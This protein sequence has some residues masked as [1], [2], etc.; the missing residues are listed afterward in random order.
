MR[1][2]AFVFATLAFMAFAQDAGQGIQLYQSGDY[3]QAEKVLA[4]AVT[5]DPNNGQAELYYGMTLVVRKKPK[6]AEQA[7]RK[8]DALTPSNAKVKA[9]L[10]GAMIDQQRLDDASNYLQQAATIDATDAD[11]IYQ[12]GRLSL[13]RRKYQD[14]AND[15]DQVISLQPKNAYAYYYDGLAYNGLG[16]LD[17]ALQKFQIFL[18]LAPNAPEAT[19][20]R[21]LMGNVR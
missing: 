2:I 17:Q 9:G 3:E 10:A 4:A 15:L 8:A 21:A 19:R 5:Q 16:K 11:Y 12:R 18:Q 6:D 13:A 1:G 14:A 20:V 7:F